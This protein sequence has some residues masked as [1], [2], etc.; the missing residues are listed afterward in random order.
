MRERKRNRFW[1]NLIESIFFSTL[2]PQSSGHWVPSIQSLFPLGRNPHWLYHSWK[3]DWPHTV[4]SSSHRRQSGG[5]ALGSLMFPPGTLHPKWTSQRWGH[6]GKSFT[7]V[8]FELCNN[9]LRRRCRER[10]WRCHPHCL[11]FWMFLQPGTLSSPRASAA[12]QRVCLVSP[13]QWL[14]CLS[15]SVPISK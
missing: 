3:Q 14:K 2:N 6:S 13:C 9:V 12:I 1:E 4:L 10:W 5:W 15:T 7:V 8:M 11:G